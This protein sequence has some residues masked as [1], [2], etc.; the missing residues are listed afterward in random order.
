MVFFFTRLHF[1]QLSR[2]QLSFKR[3]VFGPLENVLMGESSV[4]KPGRDWST[5]SEHS[6][7]YTPGVY[8]KVCACWALYLLTEL[9]HV[10]I[11]SKEQAT[12]FDDRS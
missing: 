5:H 4:V 1:P 6:R 3:L 11:H 12:N 8:S 9:L 10:Y 7:M 2:R